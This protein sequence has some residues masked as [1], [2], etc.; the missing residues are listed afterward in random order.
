MRNSCVKIYVSAGMLLVSIHRAGFFG[1]DYPENMSVV[2][3]FTFLRVRYWFR[4][5]EPAFLPQIIRKTCQL[6]QNLHSCGSAI[7]F[8][9][10]SRLFWHRLSGK[11]VSCVKIYIPAGTLLG[12]I[13][14]A[15]F[16]GT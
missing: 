2:S 4:Y 5:T 15:G 13:R 16:F 7:G 9:T 11:H 14:R 3:K 8:D 12:S 1:T 6:C 10:Q